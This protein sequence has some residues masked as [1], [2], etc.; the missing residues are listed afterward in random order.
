MGQLLRLAASSQ[1]LWTSSGL[2]YFY[3]SPIGP[4]RGLN[5]VMVLE[6][7]SVENSI[8]LSRTIQFV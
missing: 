5:F 8:L 4:N 3:R 1:A 6:S 7:V 2:F